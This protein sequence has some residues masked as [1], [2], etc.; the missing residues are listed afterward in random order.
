YLSRYWR[1]ALD[2]AGYF[3][4]PAAPPRITSCSLIGR[5]SSAL[6]ANHLLFFC[7]FY[8]EVACTAFLRSSEFLI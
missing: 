1:D 5:L 4:A 3:S 7:A 8:H 6:L 2:L